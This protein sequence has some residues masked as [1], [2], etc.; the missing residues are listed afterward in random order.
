MVSAL[1]ARVAELYT[2]NLVT[3]KVSS[4]FNIG[5]T[6]TIVLNSVRNVMPYD[7]AIVLL[8]DQDKNQFCTRATGDGRGFHLNRVWSE[9]E[10]PTIHSRKEGFLNQYFEKHSNNKNIALLVADMS[11]L[12]DIGLKYEREWGDFAP[13][14]Y[15]GV[16]LLYKDEIVGVIELAS[17]EPR[18]F[19]TDHSRVL[20]LIAGQV[21]IAVRNSLDVENREAE[22]RKQIDELQIV[23]DEGKK[24][25]SVEE[26][27]D[28]DFFQDL[29]SKADDIRE[30]R[31]VKSKR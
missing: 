2:I 7:R 13:R 29:S 1:N 14:S 28:S 11:I 22:L 30:K 15:L 23:I 21:A 26:I 20:E 3:R 27:V 16:P 25:K 24:Q 31:R 10:R 17:D 9:A 8:Y 5:N 6:L 18:S 19:T 4:S 12:P